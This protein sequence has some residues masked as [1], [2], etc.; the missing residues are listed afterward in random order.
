ME[1]TQPT[2]PV[3]FFN[4]PYYYIKFLTP[5]P[6]SFYLEINVNY[7]WQ[8]GYNSK[9]EQCVQKCTECTKQK[10]TQNTLNK[11]VNTKLV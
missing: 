3:P 10:T 2:H 5:L 11:N 4:R 9:N 8:N 7:T 1:R 6:L